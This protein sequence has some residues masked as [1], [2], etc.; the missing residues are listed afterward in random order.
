MPDDSLDDSRPR[1]GHPLRNEG[2]IAIRGVERT[3][4][5]PAMSLLRNSRYN[6]IS[7]MRAIA[8]TLLMALAAA[9]VATGK[10]VETVQPMIGAATVDSL[11]QALATV[12]VTVTAGRD[13]AAET[14]R[15]AKATSL[16]AAVEAG[17]P[18]LEG[19][20]KAW[21]EQAIEDGTQ[22]MPRATKEQL[23]GF[24]PDMLLN[25]VRYR[26]GWSRRETVE[27]ALFGL[28]DARALTLIDVIVFRDE[29][30]AADP[31]IWAHELAHVQ[32]FDI[33]GTPDFARRYVRDSGAVEFE[34]WEVAARYTMWTLQEGRLR[35]SV[36]S[37][38]PL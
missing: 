12:R 8:L 4:D 5:I 14:W 20:I 1:G 15:R 38:A 18:I 23:V 6:S 32:Q 16:D 2:T 9:S 27:S 37:A 30:V 35:A 24:F 10:F 17:A 36:L 21:R 34:A 28:S 11:H 3:A 19:W 13:V 26:I 31:A 22:A 25:R 7:A 29:A 33:W